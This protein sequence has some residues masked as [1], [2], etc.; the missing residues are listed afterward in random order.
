M[1]GVSSPVVYSATLVHWYLDASARCQQPSG[2]LCHSGPLIS[3]H[4][5]QVTAAQWCTLPLW[6]TPC[7]DQCWILFSW[8]QFVSD[9]GC[10]AEW[11]ALWPSQWVGKGASD[12]TVLDSGYNGTPTSWSNLLITT[13]YTAASPGRHEISLDFFKFFIISG[14]SPP[15][16]NESLQTK[17]LAQWFC[18]HTYNQ[19]LDLYWCSSWL[20]NYWLSGGSKHW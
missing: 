16:T 17:V 13:M 9:R 8:Y 12:S 2:V 6:S 11:I 20:D 1:P 7:C 4:Q 18:T 3:R 19:A 5:C 14:A 10:M 15:H